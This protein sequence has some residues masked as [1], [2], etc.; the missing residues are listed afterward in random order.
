MMSKDTRLKTWIHE[1]KLPITSSSFSFTLDVIPTAN[2][3]TSYSWS[4]SA[5]CI[6][7]DLSVDLI[8]QFIIL[9]IEVLITFKRII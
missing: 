7:A 2:T 4:S 3:V 8:I 1:G 5:A 9:F 6:V